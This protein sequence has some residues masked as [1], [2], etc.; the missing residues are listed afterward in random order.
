MTLPD[1]YEADHLEAQNRMGKLSYY[2]QWILNNF[3]PYVGSRIWDAGAGVGHVSSLLVSKAAF[4]M[5][6]EY[7]EENLRR[8]NQRFDKLDDV[9]VRPCDLLDDADSHFESKK[10]N[11]ILNLDVLEHLENDEKAL[12]TFY[13]NLVEGGHVLIKVPAHPFLFGTMD[14]ASLHYRRYTKAE[15]RRKLQAAGFR[16]KR[17]RYM[18]MFAVIP[19]L[20]KG[21]VLK[22]TGNFSR[23]INTQRLGFYNRLMPW[24]ECIERFL[25]PL[26]GLSL[27]AVGEKPKLDVP[28]E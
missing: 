5:S 26:F 4:L 10:F 7:T 23:E 27:V 17:I 1:S 21:R 28:G 25:P 3:S 6:T 24:L 11:T 18:N 9:E 20:I 13:R 12:A 22:R 8:L 19:Y 15:L 14:D 2:Y 16:V